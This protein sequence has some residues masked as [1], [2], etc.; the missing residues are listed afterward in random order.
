MLSLDE[1]LSQLRAVAARLGRGRDEETIQESI[2]GISLYCRQMKETH[3]QEVAQLRDEI[4]ILHEMLAKAQVHE[5]RVAAS[6]SKAE[7]TANLWRSHLQRRAEIEAHIRGVLDRNGTC[8]TVL[9]PVPSPLIAPGGTADTRR[10]AEVGRF[11][12][13][14]QSG[15]AGDNVTVSMWTTKLAIVLP[16][17]VGR[18]FDKQ[19]LPETFQI[20]EASYIVRARARE[21]VS[22][23]GE[24]SDDYLRRIEEKGK[25]ANA[26]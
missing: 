19:A 23:P 8:T 10:L 12:T 2:L 15:Q 6:Q 25:T 26:S 5:R 4:R 9:V 14:L 16:A 13:A 20:N 21:V 7:E 1:E 18:A 11:L 17:G 22:A 24:R 3:V